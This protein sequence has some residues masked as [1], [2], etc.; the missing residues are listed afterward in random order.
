YYH[1]NS[2]GDYE[3]QQVFYYDPSGDA[4]LEDYEAEEVYRHL[5]QDLQ[6]EPLAGEGIMH[7]LSV[8]GRIYMK[9]PETGIVHMYDRTGAEI[10]TVN[11]GKH[12]NSWTGFAFFDENYLICTINS[13]DPETYNNS[14][15][16]L[17]IYDVKESGKIASCKLPFADNEVRCLAISDGYLYYSVPVLTEGGMETGR[18]IYREKINGFSCAM[19][20]SD[21]IAAVS[22]RIPGA[23]LNYGEVACS[24]GTRDAA[25]TVLDDRCCY[26]DY[27]EER[28]DLVWKETGKEP[29]GKAGTPT[30]AKDMH[31]EFSDLGR[32]EFFEENVKTK[33]QEAQ[34]F[35]GY[36]EYFYFDETDEVSKKMNSLLSGVYDGIADYGRHVAESAQEEY[37]MM[38][39]D[40]EYGVKWFSAY[41]YDWNFSYARKIGAH[42]AEVAF[43]E[44]DFEGGAHGYPGM[45]FLLFD[46]NTGE[47]LTLS[48]L[49]PGTEEEFKDL[50]AK[51][52][53]EDW[54]KADEYRYYTSYAD[55]EDKEAAEKE[56]LGNAKESASLYMLASFEE[57]GITVYY[58]P[59][60]MGSY[61]SGF[62]EIAIPY[63]KLGFDLR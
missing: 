18:E 59:Y 60:D 21:R 29:S 56:M 62:I 4:F 39:E 44:Y 32:T 38:K 31:L 24:M 17:E 58:Y 42:Y 6:Y 37:D 3:N 46:L 5:R 53:V 41:T 25:F 28:G 55:S 13:Y 48:D 47:E 14:E 36:Y 54:K 16:T 50:V 23:S 2:S 11:C 49:Y 20:D 43:N 45:R 1:V 61:A 7:D 12:E 10:G 26:I 40:E 8:A 34:C 63:E 51:Y 35:R 30:G 19:Q 52:T 27:D 22:T 33:D 15:K 57:D 9:D